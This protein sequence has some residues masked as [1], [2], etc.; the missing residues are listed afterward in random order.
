MD[1]NNKRENYIRKLRAIASFYEKFPEVPLPY[2]TN[3]NE[4]VFVSWEE[5]QTIARALNVQLKGADDQ[6]YLIVEDTLVFVASP[7][8]KTATIETVKAKLS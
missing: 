2:D 4:Y 1:N 3:K 8:S 7:T 6:I 5:V